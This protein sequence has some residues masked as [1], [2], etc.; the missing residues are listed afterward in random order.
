MPQTVM[1]TVNW[2]IFQVDSELLGLWKLFLSHLKGEEEK[3]MSRNRKMKSYKI[4]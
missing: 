4:R 3:I 1:A 2:R